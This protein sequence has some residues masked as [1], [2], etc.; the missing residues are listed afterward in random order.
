HRDWLNR[1]NARPVPAAT[2]P[3]PDATYERAVQQY[4]AHGMT[5][6]QAHMAAARAHPDLHRDWLNRVN[7]RAAA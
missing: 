5:L 4:Q 6:G 1:V 3:A 2:A 7:N